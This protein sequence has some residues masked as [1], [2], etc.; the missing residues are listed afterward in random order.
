M[1]KWVRKAGG[2]DG[3]M[4]I[5]VLWY[6]DNPILLNEKPMIYNERWLC[7]V[8]SEQWMYNAM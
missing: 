5:C 8:I 7:K 4:N 2:D 1:D 6:T 3:V